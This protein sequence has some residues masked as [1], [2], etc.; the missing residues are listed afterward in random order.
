MTTS[1][2][3]SAGDESS[4]EGVCIVILKKACDHPGQ[5]AK[6]KKGK[7]TDPFSLAV[8]EVV[9][10]YVET[11]TVDTIFLDNDTRT[12]YHLPGVTFTINLRH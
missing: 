3:R 6:E 5:F 8:L 9:Q 12:S 7:L 1:I 4:V 10:K 2:G 11:L